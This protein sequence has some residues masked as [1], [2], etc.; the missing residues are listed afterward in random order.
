MPWVDPTS[1][2]LFNAFLACPGSEGSSCLAPIRA[3]L[4]SRSSEQLHCLLRRR[5]M[6][7]VGEVGTAGS[8]LALSYTNGCTAN[9]R[10]SNQIES[11]SKKWKLLSVVMTS[12]SVKQ[13]ANSFSI[14][15]II[16]TFPT[17]QT[18]EPSS[19]ICYGKLQFGIC[20]QGHKKQPRFNKTLQNLTKPYVGNMVKLRVN[21]VKNCGFLRVIYGFLRVYYGYVFFYGLLRPYNLVLRPPIWVG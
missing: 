5:D 7:M 2:C 17:A 12:L 8:N 6:A 20:Q 1:I 19:S 18:D 3:A 14:T 11:V 10:Y 9:W 21:Y 4:A 15:G 13:S 16:H